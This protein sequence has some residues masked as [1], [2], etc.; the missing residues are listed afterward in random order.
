MKKAKEAEPMPSSVTIGLPR[1][2]LYHRY[3]VLW[4]NYFSTLGIDCV[5]SEPTN[6]EIIKSGTA[7]SIDEACLCTK[8]YLGHVKSLLGKCDFIL[9]PR[10]SNFGVKR[11]MCTKFESLYDMV[12]NTFRK[13]NQNFI[14]YN[15]DV[16]NGQTEEKALTKL[17]MELGFSKKASLLAYKT[18][19]KAEADYLKN[20]IKSYEDLYKKNGLKILIVSHIYVEK[21][22]YIGIP[23]TNYL[24]KMGAIPIYAD[25]VDRKEALKQSERISPTLKWE[26]SRELVGS[27]Q[28]HADKIDGIILLSAFPCGPDSMVDEMIIRK[29][30]GIPTL[31]IV[32]DDQDGTAGLETR[33]ESFIDILNFKGGRL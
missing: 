17:A 27:I 15:V 3:E 29:F 11:N 28:M 26:F 18:A 32:L 6:K 4:K 12:C 9:V 1:A 24:K 30:H 33:L 20:K 21:D 16:I 13:T 22:P 8:I 2:M 23:V 5:I 7:V 31:N 10:I 19:K 25:T 14:S